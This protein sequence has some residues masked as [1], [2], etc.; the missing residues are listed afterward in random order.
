MIAPRV[1]RRET[2]ARS[3]QG[4]VEFA[5][6]VPLFMLLLLGLLEFGFVFDH[7]MTVSYATRE[8]ARS[9]AAFAQGNATTM[10]AR[11]RDVDKNIVAAVQRVLKARARLV[12]SADIS[13]I[14]IYKAHAERDA[15]A[16]Q[17]R[18]SGPTAPAAVRSSTGRH[19]DF[20]QGT[21]GWNACTRDNGSSP[22]SIGVSIRYN[23]RFVTPLAVAPG[24]SSAHPGRAG[25]ADPDRTVMALNPIK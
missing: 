25:V 17:A 6:L 11:Q 15:R 19:L 20:V 23:Y 8:G 5:M 18:T 9:G 7:A 14:R 21:V 13:E 1:A 16:D 10:S 3:G 24:A 4:L 2:D 12:E 22:D